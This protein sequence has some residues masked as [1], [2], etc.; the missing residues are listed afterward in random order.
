MKA[1]HYKDTVFALL[2]KMLVYGVIVAIALF[3]VH[4]CTPTSVNPV[5]ASLTKTYINV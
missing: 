1:V 5:P 2:L 3:V 4:T